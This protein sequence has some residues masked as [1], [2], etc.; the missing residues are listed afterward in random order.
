MLVTGAAGQDGRLLARKLLGGGLKVTGLCKAGHGGILLKY[1]PGIN[2]IEVDLANEKKLVEILNSVQPDEIYN[3]AGFS[4]V[5]QSWKNP[6][7]VA[8]INSLVPAIILKWCL[9]TKP[10]TR[11][12]QASSSEV[13]G[14]STSSPQNEST[15]HSPITPYGLSKSFSHTLLQQFRNEY[16]LHVSNAILYNHE[17]PLRDVHFVTRK[18]TR[19]LAN[20]SQGLE[21]CLFMGNLDALR[22]WGHAK[23]YIRMQWMMLQQQSPNDFV[24]ATGL[25]HTVRDFIQLSAKQLGLALKFEGKGVD[26]VARV[27]EIKG[28]KAPA[29]KVGDII[30]RIDPKNFRLTEV[31]ALLGDSSKAMK[32]LGW[33]PQ[34]SI[35]EMCKE[36]IEFDLNEARKH[37]FLKNNGFDNHNTY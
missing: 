34:I 35:E 2:V 21:K 3:L 16:G 7:M 12:L 29:L 25:Q 8:A 26:E 14:A 17:S 11:L 31:E 4:S 28:D 6:E 1:C 33:T 37:T 30:M 13:F 22:D 32:L 15:P 23:D 19:G 9:E 18:I 20:V 36:M 5:N 10:T 27:L 24:I